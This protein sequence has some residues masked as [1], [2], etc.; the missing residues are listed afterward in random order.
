MTM[1]VHAIDSSAVPRLRSVDAVGTPEEYTTTGARSRAQLNASILQA[2]LDVS[3]SSRNEPLALLYRSAIDAINE[4]LQPELGDNAL[5]AAMSQDNTP[6]GTAGRIVALSTGF[7]EA[8]KTQHAGEDEAEVL[9]NFMATI[10][11]GFERGFKEAVDILK[12]LKVFEGD[13]AS[14]IEK[15][16]ALVLQG[17][18]DF[19]A[20]HTTRAAEPLA[21]RAG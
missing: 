5:Q 20:A 18:A 14:N 17:Y 8:F 21:D 15:T 13:I 2:S 10:R 9:Q 1:P 19:E 7:L 16:H 12:G 11:S 6:E 4:A 3:I